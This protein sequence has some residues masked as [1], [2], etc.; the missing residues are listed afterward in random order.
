MSTD[1]SD[2]GFAKNVFSTALAGFGQRPPRRPPEEAAAAASAHDEII[3]ST[4]RAKAKVGRPAK[5]VSNIEARRKA[6]K[7]A[8][9]KR[10]KPAR[11]RK[12]ATVGLRCTTRQKMILLALQD[13]LEVDT[14]SD[15]AVYAILAVAAGYEIKGA[16]EELEA[17][18]AER[19]GQ[20]PSGD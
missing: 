11:A 20:E 13:R 7:A 12:N 9:T 3:D 10:R 4:P 8:T 14:I 17:V 15:A 6:E 1:T 18:E 5:P 19:V 16:V 2:V